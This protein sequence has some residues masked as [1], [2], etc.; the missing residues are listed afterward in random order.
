MGDF[1]V[2]CACPALGTYCCGL[3]AVVSSLLLVGTV[4]TAAEARSAASAVCAAAASV[5]CAHRCERPAAWRRVVTLT[6]P[7]L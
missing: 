4:T 5:A 6:L 1:E 2:N 3:C 7:C